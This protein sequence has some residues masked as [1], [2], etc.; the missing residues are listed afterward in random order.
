MPSASRKSPGL[1]GRCTRRS[2][3]EAL[4]ASSRPVSSTF[5][6]FVEPSDSCSGVVEHRS[7]TSLWVLRSASAS[8]PRRTGSC[9]AWHSS[10]KTRSMG[11]GLHRSSCC[12]CHTVRPLSPCG[13]MGI[14]L[15]AKKSTDS[16]ITLRAELLSST[17][18]CSTLPEKSLPGLAA[19]RATSMPMALL[20]M[21][22]GPC[23]AQARRLRR[24]VS[25]CCMTAG[26]KKSSTEGGRKVSCSWKHPA[27]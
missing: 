23:S 4:R 7:S 15:A 12:S 11:V 17:L 9:S 16:L 22:L 20:P 19:K 6:T 1:S 5:T 18:T 8:R 14:C 2:S 13:S 27:S 21:P 3:S 25:T 24:S 10:S 26:R